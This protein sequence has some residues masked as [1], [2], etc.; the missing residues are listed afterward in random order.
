[1]LIDDSSKF[2]LCLLGEGGLDAR[3]LCLSRGIAILFT[4]S[5]I[6]CIRECS[7]KD[8]DW[9]FPCHSKLCEQL[10]HMRIVGL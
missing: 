10:D 1:M 5:Y 4:R 3:C 9:R 6:T 8:S 7:L 2:C